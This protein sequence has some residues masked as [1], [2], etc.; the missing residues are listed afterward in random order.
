MADTLGLL[1]CVIVT[2][3]SVQDRDGEHPLLA[4]LGERLST[5]RLVWTDCV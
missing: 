1:L 4:L 5:I 3:V 2:A